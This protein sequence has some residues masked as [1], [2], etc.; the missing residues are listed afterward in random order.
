L[1]ENG[2]TETYRG[3]VEAWECD[4][5]GHMNVAFYGE[6]FGDAAAS[7]LFAHAPN[8]SWRSTSLFVRYLKELREGESVTIGS[9]VIGTSEV[10]KGERV[11]RIGHEMRQ[12]DGQICTVA[13][14][15]LAPFDAKMRGTLT[16]TL[17]GKAGPWKSEGFAAIALPVKHGP[18]PTIRDRVKSWEVDER[19]RLSLFGHV[20][21]FSTASGHLMNMVGLT[22]DYI[23]KAK[24]GFATFET[25]LALAPFQPGAGAE[26]AGSSGLMKV[27]NSS[28]VMIHDLI[29]VR[30]GERIAR[31]Y[32]AGVHFDL[33]K[34]EGA[35]LPDD[36]RAK[37]MTMLIKD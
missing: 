7:L 23:H 10:N 19:G 30:N 16:K 34:R 31:F 22:A 9:A 26:V 1:A 28:V 27:G 14:H 12:S 3:D 11:A 6:R 25:R 21:R 15:A 20:R 37:A 18:Y 8:R 4:S 32:Q 36:L 13:E 35:P 5:F 24:R 17:D 2:L 33:D 29:E